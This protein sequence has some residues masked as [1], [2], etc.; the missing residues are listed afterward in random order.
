MVQ[1]A[2]GAMARALV[3]SSL[4]LARLGSRCD[5]FVAAGIGELLLRV[6]A[7]TAVQTTVLRRWMMAS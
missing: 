7:V 6:D 2:G 1:V 3:A 5:A 4:V